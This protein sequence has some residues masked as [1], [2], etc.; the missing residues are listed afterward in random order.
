M[1]KSKRRRPFRLTRKDISRFLYLRSDVILFLLGGYLKIIVFSML[2][3]IPVSPLAAILS[4]AGLCLLAFF[5]SLTADTLFRTVRVIFWDSLLSLLIVSDL[6]YSRYFSDV[7]SWPALYAA[8]QLTAVSSSVK[9]LFE[10]WDFLFFADLIPIFFLLYF[11]IRQ[12]RERKRILKLSSYKY[13]RRNLLRAT[14]IA[15]FA[16]MITSGWAIY[17][18]SPKLFTAF[19]ENRQAEFPT[20]YNYV[21]NMGILNF[22]VFDTGLFLKRLL[23]KPKVSAEQM[24]EV[25]TWFSR[26]KNIQK[27]EFWGIAQGNNVIILLVESLQEFVIG[28]EINGQPVTPNLNTLTRESCYFKNFFHQTAQGRTIDAEFVSLT[29]LNPLRAGSVSL[30]YPLHEYDSISKVL[31]Q[32]SYFT[33]LAQAFKSNFWNED[34][35][36]KTLGFDLH[37]TEE[38]FEIKEV[39]ALGLSDVH[40]LNQMA[41]KIA[42]MPE[43]FFAVVVTLSSHHPYDELPEKYRTLNVGKWRGTMMG[44]Y[45]QSANYTDKA[46]G[47]FLESLKQS[48]LYAKTVLAVLGDHDAGLTRN[49]LAEIK[50]VAT[51]DF[52]VKLLDKVPLI[53]HL[54]QIDTGFISEK[55]GGT[56]DMTPTLLYLLGIDYD[57]NY[58]MGRSLFGEEF[59]EPVVF[60]NGSALTSSLLYLQSR[61]SRADGPCYKQPSGQ[62]VAAENCSTIREEARQRL[63]ISD[64]IIQTNLLSELKKRKRME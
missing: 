11:R 42:K 60:R 54:P 40:F 59:P 13:L 23:F 33:V 14:S 15:V 22:H 10:P 24:K 30:L 9:A 47:E 5:F 28:L 3:H 43:P 7:I 58:F 64:L 61:S 20:N 53:I 45:L 38:S 63:D 34:K 2:V 17:I 57:E 62:L 39:I 18:Q 8:T 51:T 41:A 31:K 36:S 55:Y 4:L 32:T 19:T 26:R 6:V 52:N 1:Q 27:N 16:A 29:S 21:A 35:M 48:G 50:N 56:L 49:E 12:S 25:E 46:L 44:D 37:L